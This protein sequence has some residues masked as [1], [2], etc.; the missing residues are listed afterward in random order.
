MTISNLS[1]HIVT[2]DEIGSLCRTL[3]DEAYQPSC[4]QVLYFLLQCAVQHDVQEWDQLGH[5]LRK[6][7]GNSLQIATCGL[8]PKSHSTEEQQGIDSAGPSE[9]WG[10]AV[11]WKEEADGGIRGRFWISS[12]AQTQYGTS[13]DEQHHSSERSSALLRTL[14]HT[15]FEPFLHRHSGKSIFFNGTNQRWTQVLSELGHKEYDGICT[16]AA[17]RV[18]LQEGRKVDCPVGYRLRPLEEKDIDTVSIPFKVVV[19][20]S[21][22]RLPCIR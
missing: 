11:L 22:Y 13:P 15:F 20:S 10:V 5:A 19:N 14:C 21:I 16:K 18:S 12:E 8:P 2:D 4:I 1:A 3:S 6:T 9:P 17:R 7:H